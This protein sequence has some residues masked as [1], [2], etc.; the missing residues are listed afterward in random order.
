MMIDEYKEFWGG[1]RPYRLHPR[2]AEACGEFL[3]E[4]KCFARMEFVDSGEFARKLKRELEENPGAIH[5]NMYC[6]PFVGDLE[7]AKV[8]FL[9]G[10]PGLNEASD[11]YDEHQNEAFMAALD[12]NLAFR[13][14]EF[15]PLGAFAEGTSTGEYWGKA[16]KGL[17]NALVEGTGLKFV[18][19]QQML[20]RDVCV[21]QSVGYHSKESPRVKPG[22][23]PSSEMTRRLVHEYF[24]PK[25]RKGEVVILAW[26]QVNFWGLED[27]ENVLVRPR[28]RAI[29][30]HLLGDEVGKIVKFFLR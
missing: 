20:A 22:Q 28:G 14:K 21:L 9:S 26:R 29:V 18:H 10:N 23:L 17:I 7:N 3:Y 19:V 4:R 24:L 8:V 12:E 25:A 27:E 30:P 16:C 15:F 6:K 5:T 11:Y 1:Y 2:D 13:S